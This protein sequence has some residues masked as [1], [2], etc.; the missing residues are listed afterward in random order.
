MRVAFLF[1]GGKDSAY[2]AYLAKEK[3]GHELA[4]AVTMKS[5][6]PDS[7][8]FHTANIGV[9]S[10]Q[11]EKMGIKHILAP[12][13]G[14]KEK[15]LSD[16]HNALSQPGIEGVVSG[17]VASEYQKSRVDK[18]CRELG[19]ESIAPL[20]RMNQVQLLNKIVASGFDAVISSVSA[21]GFSEEWL[22]RHIDKNCV[23]DIE[24]LSK[25]YGINPSGEGG[26]YCTTV[27]NC[28]LFSGAIKVLKARREWSGSSGK[29]IIEECG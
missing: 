10:K 24:A 22:G 2:A 15:E 9:T 29:Y 27:L 13:K 8:M 19:L 3:L 16:L 20:W 17:A 11:C 4:Y 7:Y 14:E 5:E 28:P 21:G 23:N 18:I 12:T 25:R 6:N 26:E 1:S